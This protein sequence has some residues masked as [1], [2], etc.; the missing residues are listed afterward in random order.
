MASL[1]SLLAA[2]DMT[3]ALRP[4]ALFIR[5]SYAAWKYRAAALQHG[6]LYRI[7]AVCGDNALAAVGSAAPILNLLLVLFIG[8]SA[9]ASIMIAQYFGAQG[10][11]TPFRIGGDLYHYDGFGLAGYYDFGAFGVSSDLGSA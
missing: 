1:R 10:P 7:R 5:D 11:Q 8:V 6:G 2:Q 3:V 4:N 9:G